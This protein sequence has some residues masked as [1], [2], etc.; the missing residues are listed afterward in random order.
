[1]AKMADRETIQ[2]MAKLEPQFSSD[3]AIMTRVEQAAGGPD[4]MRCHE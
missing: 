4:R 1:M 3:D 2:A